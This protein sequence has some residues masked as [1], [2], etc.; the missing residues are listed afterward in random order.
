[1]RPQKAARAD[2]VGKAKNGRH[3]RHRHAVAR[4]IVLTCSTRAALLAVA[5]SERR[6]SGT[7]QLASV[8]PTG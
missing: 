2:C 5:T 7:C 6:D 4:E 8:W 1:M 3:L